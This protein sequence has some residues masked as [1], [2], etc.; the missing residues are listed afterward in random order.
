M[1]VLDEI[2]ALRKEAHSH[3]QVLLQHAAGRSPQETAFNITE[4]ALENG[5]PVREFFAAVYGTGKLNLFHCG[6]CEG[7]ESCA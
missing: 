1:E 7:R 2:D 4:L 5:N 3:L 6:L